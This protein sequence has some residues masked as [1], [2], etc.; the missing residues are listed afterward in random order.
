MWTS[1]ASRLALL[2]AAAVCAS[3]QTNAPPAPGANLP[4]A[5]KARCQEAVK[6]PLPSEANV[7]P[8]RPTTRDNSFNLYYG[9]NE[10]EQDLK[11]ARALA[12][13]ERAAAPPRPDEGPVLGATLIL[14]MI[15]ADGDGVAR[16]PALALRLGCEANLT[17]A[18]LEALDKVLAS[19]ANPPPRFDICGSRSTVEKIEFVCSFVHDGQRRN[20]MLEE[21]GKLTA[22][23][24]PEQRDAAQ[25]LNKAERSYEISSVLWEDGALRNSKPPMRDIPFEDRSMPLYYKDDSAFDDA[26]LA[27]WGEL[28]TGQQAPGRVKGDDVELNRSYRELTDRLRSPSKQIPPGVVLPLPKEIGVE[29][30]WIAY[31]DTWGA[32]VGMRFGPERASAWLERLTAARTARIRELSGIYG[33]PTQAAAA[34]LAACALARTVPLPADISAEPTHPGK[35]WCQSYKPYYGIGVSRDFATARQCAIAERNAVEYYRSVNV[36]LPPQ[37]H[38]ED[39]EIGIEI[40]G[41]VVLMALY[42]NGEGVTRNPPLARRFACEA[43]DNGQISEVEAVHLGASTSDDETK[44]EDLLNAIVSPQPGHLD[45][46]DWVSDVAREQTECDLIA[47]VESNQDREARLQAIRSKFTPDQKEA[48]DKLLAALR[49]YLD[50]HDHNEV[51]VMGHYLFS[52]AW[53]G[54]HREREETFQTS[55]DEFEGGKF[56][57]ATTAQYAQADKALNA[58]YAQSIAGAAQS[59]STTTG[60]HL[61]GNPPTRASIRATERLWLAYRDAFAD[62]GTLRYPKTTR[63][64]W[65]WMVTQKRANDLSDR[66]FMDAPCDQGK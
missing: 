58:A 54:I 18:D 36:N 34:R 11:R 38:A 22:D 42:A 48:F 35:H 41:S 3:A 43:I 4:A 29:R 40:N 60:E 6:T 50:A 5:W 8:P 1:K 31:R 27:Q 56:P 21:I 51:E 12:W 39:A 20:R 64:A 47:T 19:S 65:L 57:H 62:F 52:G 49:A 23:W 25:A 14:A 7:P 28:V 9:I 13:Q 55:L 32:V 45:P 2:C 66:C 30:D 46:C 53:Q 33:P 44:Y 37:E 10:V 15:Y 17:G 24:T 59:E 16:D 26:Y 61:T 63:E